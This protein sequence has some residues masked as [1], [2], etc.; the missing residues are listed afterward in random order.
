MTKIIDLDVVFKS[1]QFASDEKSTAFNIGVQKELKPGSR[2]KA[3]C[4]IPADFIINKLENGGDLGFQ[5][6]VI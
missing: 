6:D 3:S 5:A 2:A 1:E 4:T